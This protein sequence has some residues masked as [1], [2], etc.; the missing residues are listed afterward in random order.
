M[1]LCAGEGSHQ[2][3]KN[4]AQVLGKPQSQTD[5]RLVEDR[6]EVGTLPNM[7]AL[8]FAD[9]TE[10]TLPAEMNLACVLALHILHIFKLPMSS[11]C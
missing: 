6:L 7:H 11:S 3:G 1:L 9:S 2:L 8:L 5:K 4:A 10:G